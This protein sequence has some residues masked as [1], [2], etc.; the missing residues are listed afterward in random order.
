MSGEFTINAE[1]R[2]DLG[3]GAS[4][5]L[6]R[7]E[8]KVLGI[9]YGGSDA[10]APL[11]CATNEIA[12][13]IQNEA[14]F[15]SIVDL[16]LDGKVQKVVVKDM[17]RHPAKDSVMHID[18]LRVDASTKITMHVPLH[19]INE[20]IC[21]GVKMEGGTISHALNDIEVS[22]LPKDLPEYIEVDM[23][24]LSTG[25]NIHLSDLTL[26]TGVESVALAHGEDHDLLVSAVNAPRGGG[27]EDDE[28]AA[29][30]ADEGE[31]PAED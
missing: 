13:L 21:H 19:F 23:A 30:D 28:E 22:C 31:A 16:N 10:P 27:S 8:N 24:G 2:T 14:F 15:T 20:D 7:L 29:T 4:R 5:R 25:E 18:L 1:S 9:V 3:K 17:Q 12:K 6:R 11:T 26:P